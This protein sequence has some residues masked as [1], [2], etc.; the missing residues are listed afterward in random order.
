MIS[1]CFFVFF[2]GRVENMKFGLFFFGDGLW[3]WWIDGFKFPIF[4]L[5]VFS[6]LCLIR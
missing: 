1:V 4:L 6:G 3:L 2:L 5:T